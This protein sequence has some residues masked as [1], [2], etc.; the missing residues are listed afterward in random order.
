MRRQEDGLAR[1]HHG[2][3]HLPELLGPGRVEPD[4]RL[5]HEEHL[6]VGE[7]SP[8]DV[9]ALPH[10]AGVLLHGALAGLG[11]TYQLDYLGDALAGHVAPEVVQ[12]R[13]VF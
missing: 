5:V 12:R 11:Q 4:G 13:E 2:R 3:Y 8:G 10:A 9:Q 7:Q 1:P 6:G